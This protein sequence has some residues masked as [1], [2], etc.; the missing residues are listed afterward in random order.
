MVLCTVVYCTVQVVAVVEA[1]PKN[2]SKIVDSE[3]PVG[4]KRS[5]S[6]ATGLVIL[7]EF[8]WMDSRCLADSI[9]SIYSIY[10]IQYP[11]PP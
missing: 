2:I 9:Y 6:F 7:E 8:I 11:R 3:G 5:V 1:V 10:S 4:R